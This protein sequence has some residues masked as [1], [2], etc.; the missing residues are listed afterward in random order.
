MKEED[1]NRR[2]EENTSQHGRIRKR[3]R[4]SRPEGEGAR[5]VGGVG[6]SSCP[7]QYH[8]NSILLIWYQYLLKS[9]DKDLANAL[10]ALK[11]LHVCASQ[12]TPVTPQSH[13]PT[14]R[15]P[16]PAHRFCKHRS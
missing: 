9:I 13:E 1:G 6:G 8:I 14:A 10:S 4:A 16:P 7:D 12:Q 2:R 5:G 15:P 11:R 3:Q